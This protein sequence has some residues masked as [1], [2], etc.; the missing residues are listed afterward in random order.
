MDYGKLADI[1]ESFISSKEEVAEA[2]KILERKTK[3]YLKIKREARKERDDAIALRIT[4]ESRRNYVIAALE[5]VRHYIELVELDCINL[6]K[7]ASTQRALLKERRKVIDDLN[8]VNSYIATVDNH[9]DSGRRLPVRDLLEK[10]KP[11]A[12]SYSTRAITL[13]DALDKNIQQ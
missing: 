7:M 13:K 3:E 2:R 4:L 12:R 1:Q 8:V 9:K 6:V 5:D 11:G 10:Q